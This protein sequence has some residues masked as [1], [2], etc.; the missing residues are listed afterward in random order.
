MEKLNEATFN[1][2]RMAGNA[3]AEIE[4]AGLH[5]DDKTYQEWNRAECP[6]ISFLDWMNGKRP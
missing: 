6:S 5:W 2:L 3:R 1:A 4:A